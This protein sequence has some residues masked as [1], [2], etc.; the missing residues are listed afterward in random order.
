MLTGAIDQS[1]KDIGENIQV[2]KN[3]RL[4]QNLFILMLIIELPISG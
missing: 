1:Q 4:G 2:K 3:L